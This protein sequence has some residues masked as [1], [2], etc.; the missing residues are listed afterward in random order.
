MIA[1]I[2]PSPDEKQRPCVPP[3]R[4]ARFFCSASRVGFLVRDGTV[5]PLALPVDPPFGVLRHG[6]YRTTDVPLRPDD[7]LI[8]LTDGMLERGAARL[9]LPA[10]LPGLTG[11]HPREVV[12]ELG[13]AILDVAGPTL[14]DDACMLVLDWHGDHGDNRSTTAGADP[15]RASALPYP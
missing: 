1:W 3:S 13:D 9:D 5:Q 12:R 14:P 6:T 11:L 4:A 7:R 8:L 15:H 2:A 10:R